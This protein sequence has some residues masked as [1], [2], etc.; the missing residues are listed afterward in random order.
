[1]DLDAVVAGTTFTRLCSCKTR[2]PLD[3]SNESMSSIPSSK[4]CSKFL[5]FMQCGG[6]STSPV[7]ITLMP[8][9]LTFAGGSI[10]AFFDRKSDLTTKA[11]T[12]ALGFA[13][14]GALIG[15]YSVIVIILRGLLDPRGAV[16]DARSGYLATE[17]ILPETIGPLRKHLEEFVRRSRNHVKQL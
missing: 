8:L 13:S 2:V 17:D 10:F 5:A 1:M 6:L 11:A 16:Q 12:S 7:T 15:T 3:S 14:W 4:R 9:L